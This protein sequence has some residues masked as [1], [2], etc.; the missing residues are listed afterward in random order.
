[1][2]NCVIKI[3]FSVDDYK[4][5]ADFIPA[6]TNGSELSMSYAKSIIAEAEVKNGI[7]WEIVQ[8]TIDYCN[9]SKKNR[10]E[11]KIATGKLQLSEV[12]SHW[13]LQG[14][15]F[16][17]AMG[18][19]DISQK[20]DY[21]EVS[22]FVL[23]KKGELI[24][25]R[26]EGRNG[27]EGLSVKG[28]NIPFKKKKIVQF[29]GGRNTT[30][31]EGKLYATTSGRYEV[32][33]SRDIHINDILHIKGDVDYSTGNISFGKDVIIEGEVKDGFKVAVGGTLYC[34]SNLDASDILCRKDLI[35]DYGIIGRGIS[36]VRVG[37]KIEARFVE[38][39]HVE[40]KAGITVEKNIMNSQIYTLGHLFLG[41]KG[42]IVSSHIYSELGV[43][44]FN[45]GKSGSP[46]TELEIGFSFV[47]KSVIESIT[48]R[49]QVL[50][51]KLYKLTR[52]PEYRKTSK[53]LDLIKQIEQVVAKGQKE[54]DDKLRNLYKYQ[55]AV[56]QVFGTIYPGNI[57]SIC[58][59]RYSVTI[60]QHRVKFYLDKESHRIESAQ[61]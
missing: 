55:D 43:R 33:E 35:A 31:H 37:G 57:I 30:E 20:V 24:A 2:S 29:T 16:K 40:S 17:S 34:K 7:D 8:S 36:L 49:I 18:F 39:C 44:V 10:M 47:D 54:L 56:V 53:K 59:V 23:V 13:S 50:K 60:E 38:N 19:D 9:Y 46:N 52:L 61:I 5:Y 42:A 32:S 1:M 25:V 27:R 21:K 6:V 4:A 14:K 15:F 41:D 28:K 11:V 3:T 48:Q 22:N 12:S 26:D 51:D 58:G 45:I